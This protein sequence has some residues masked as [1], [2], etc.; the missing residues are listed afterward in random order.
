MTARIRA[1]AVE[2]G[3]ALCRITRP[4][5]E[6][7]HTDALQHWL[8]QGM[9]GEMAWM[10]EEVRLQRRMDPAS[11]LDGVRSVV[12]LAMRYS[13]PAYRPDEAAAVA[14]KGVISAYAHG[15]DYHDVMKKRLKAL[16]RDLDGLLGPFDQRIYVDT[17]PVLEHALAGASGLGWQGKH[18]LTIDRQLGS[19]FLLGEIFTTAELLP[20]LAASNHCGS[21]SA[22]ISGC[23]TGAIV[24]PYIVDARR[25]ISYLTIEFDGFIPHALR[26]LMGNRIYGCD[27]CQMVCPW[28]A[29]AAGF[30]GL[31]VDHLTP[32]GENHLPELAS[33]LRLDEDGF[34]LRFAKS[35]VRRSR[36]S[37]L[38]RNVCIAMGNS[39]NRT[40]VPSLLAVT[41]DPEPLIRGHAVW[42]LA[43]LADR[44]CR[45]TLLTALAAMREREKNDAV[46]RELLL[47]D[48][49]IRMNHEYT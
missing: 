17:A 46:V 7:R 26:P 27:D 5:I 22:C 29:H 8:E 18:S 3:F 20:D 38:L 36:R 43:Q 42:A 45:D 40:F 34:R 14:D 4:V 32:R 16:A 2:H 39:G 10:A 24:A 6:S 12:T 11:M 44:D 28:N 9:Q 1:K 31:A 47:A 33:L 49:Q 48:E 30:G 23:P 35:P 41:G 15:D 25:C 19:W 21:C 37:K 13:P